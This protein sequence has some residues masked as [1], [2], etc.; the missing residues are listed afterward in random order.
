MHK[1]SQ[2]NER[3]RRLFNESSQQNAKLKKI[4]EE[5]NALDVA[6]EEKKR[7]QAK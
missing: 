2:E 3:L 4:V 5:S 6:I 7:D 1:L